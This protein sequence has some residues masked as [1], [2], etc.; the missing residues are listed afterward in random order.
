[1]DKLKKN[2]TIA[3]TEVLSESRFLDDT[4]VKPLQMYRQWRLMLH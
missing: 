1:M 4:D 3:H 2:S